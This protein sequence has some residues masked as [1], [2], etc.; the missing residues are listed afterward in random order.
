MEKWIEEIKKTNELPSYSG[1]SWT[2]KRD[3]IRSL[4]REIERLAGKCA[5][6]DEALKDFFK[7]LDEGD[8]M[9]DLVRD[10]SE[11]EDP[12]YAMRMLS[13]VSRL[14]KIQEA[15]TCGEKR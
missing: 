14:K 5:E 15:L 3:Q 4:V 10:I 7:M 6:K 2:C 8:L 11:D 13:F 9:R 12:G 1:P